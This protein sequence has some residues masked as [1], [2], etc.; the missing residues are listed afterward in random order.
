MIDPADLHGRAEDERI[1]D[2]REKR[3]ESQAADAAAEF[4]RTRARVCLSSDTEASDPGE[5]GCYW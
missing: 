4:A 2:K 5:D 1:R 3:I